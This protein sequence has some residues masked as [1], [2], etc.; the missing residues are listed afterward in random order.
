MPSKYNQ[1]RVTTINHGEGIFA[2]L[3]D[4]P[5]QETLNIITGRVF[6]NFG[7]RGS[8]NILISDVDEVNRQK[9]FE[10][11]KPI[12]EEKGF[13]VHL[14][15]PSDASQLQEFVKD[16]IFFLPLPFC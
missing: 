3:T 2:H 7:K 15:K 5:I 13:E 14:L 6:K 4:R 8:E 11:L 1:I 9:Y 12:M 10:I 16:G